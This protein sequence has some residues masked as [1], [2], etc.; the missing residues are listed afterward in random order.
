MQ[1]I[2]AVDENWAIGCHGRLLT[3]L[4]G[5]LKYFKEKTLNKVVV[6]GRKTLLT[7]PKQRPLKDRLNM[8]LTTDQ[9]F[10]CEDA[11]V[12][13]NIE[14]LNQDL[15][16]YKSEDVFI[17]G[18]ESVYKQMIDVC[19]IAYVTKIHQGFDGDVFF[20]NLDELEEWELVESSEL[21]HYEDITY[22]FC[23]YEKNA[24]K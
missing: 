19:D 1:C 21:Q 20:P 2:V 23:K 10:K 8:I 24:R 5:D 15:K 12:Y 17:I 4:P 3:Y 14:T 9:E 7:F 16:K 22:T 13:H 11:K 6:L 18:G